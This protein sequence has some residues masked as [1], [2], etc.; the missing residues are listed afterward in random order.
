MN[1]IIKRLKST[2]HPFAFVDTQILDIFNEFFNHVKSA[3]H[4]CLDGGR[5]TGNACVRDHSSGIMYITRTNM[6]KREITSLDMVPCVP[7]SLSGAL[8]CYGSFDPSSDTLRRWLLF[9]KFPKVS[10]ILHAHTHIIG[11]GV[12]D[13]KEVL[14][15]EDSENQDETEELIR[16]V[17][18]K[19]LKPADIESSYINVTGHGCL[20]LTDRY[21]TSYQGKV[22]QKRK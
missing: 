12:W 13:T 7:H 3:S 17:E 16:L 2:E 5:Y 6:P 4:T 15:N 18:E 8:Y 14:F 19:N 1:W 20:I 11:E 21:K 10:I 22:F 9:Q